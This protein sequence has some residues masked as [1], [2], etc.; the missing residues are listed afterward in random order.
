MGSDYYL[1]CT[2]ARRVIAIHKIRD[3]A[4][5]W[6][7]AHV[8]KADC[9]EFVFLSVANMDNSGHLI[10]ETMIR[11]YHKQMDEVTERSEDITALP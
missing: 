10:K 4:I 2:G 5:A 9:S 8:K 7:D 1:I 11:S 3:S 6:F